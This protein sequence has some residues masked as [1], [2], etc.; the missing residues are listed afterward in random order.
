MNF[1]NFYFKEDESILDNPNFKKWFGHSKVVDKNGNPLV[2]YHGSYYD[3]NE[4]DK[5]KRG[6]S[7]TLAAKKAFWFTSS[8]N[9]ATNFSG[10]SESL[11]KPAYLKIENPIVYDAKDIPG[12][13]TQ[14]LHSIRNE[15]VQTAIRKGK[16]G[17][18]FKNMHDLGGPFTIVAVF[19]PNQIKSTKNKGTF[20]SNSNNINE[21]EESLVNEDITID[22]EKKTANIDYKKNVSGISTSMGKDKNFTPFKTSGKMFGNDIVISGY[23]SKLLDN[24]SIQ[25]KELRNII[26]NLIKSKSDE[27][28]LSIEEIE[29]FVRRTIIY[30]NRFFNKN[31]LSFDVILLPKSSSALNMKMAQEFKKRFPYDV[32]LYSDEITKSLPKDLQIVGD[33]PEIIRKALQR[34]LDK[35]NTEGKFEIKKLPPSFR[36]YVSNLSKIDDKI[37]KKVEGKNVLIIDDVLTSGITISDIIKQLRNKSNPNIIYGVTLFK[38]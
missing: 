32:N 35:W 36:Q 38:N 10:G 6:Q 17:V 2:M 5:N 15:K 34:S 26:Y 12:W 20:D 11:V 24:E 7:G 31:N 4:F 21:L 3:F 19:E 27:Y 37:F 30:L 22:T 13:N 25:P 23:S 14:W 16:D 33:P 9:H 1:N 18:I 28:S 8:L 29:Y